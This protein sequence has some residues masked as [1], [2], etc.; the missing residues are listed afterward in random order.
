M[1]ACLR[2]SNFNYDWY[3]LLEAYTVYVSK[4]DTVLEIGASQVERTG[5]LASYCAKVIGV[6]LVPERTP[7]AFDNVNYISGDWQDLAGIVDES[8][9]DVTLA[10][11]V[12]EHVPDDLRAINEL[13]K[14]LKPGGVAL[15]NTP[16]RKRLTRV[17]AE[18][19][20]GERRFPHWEHQR[21]YT[22]KDLEALLCASLFR[23]WTIK[24]LVFGIHGGP[25]F[26]YLEH[27]PDRVRNYANYWEVHLFKERVPD[28][29]GGGPVR[30]RGPLPQTWSQWH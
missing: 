9:I 17:V 15:L 27:V 4:E 16:N 23:D 2:S 3:S 19:F 25:I 29:T 24:P 18:V 1:K 8:S 30:D 26:I 21:E 12:I 10:S 7:A 28:A 14:V 13:Y 22:E 6:E 5:E 11:H 20:T